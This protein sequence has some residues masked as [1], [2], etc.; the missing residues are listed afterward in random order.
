[1][2]AEMTPPA[3][4]DNEAGR[5]RA[6]RSSGL[7][8][9]GTDVQLDAIVHRAAM[10]FNVP[11]AA[12]T[13]I[14]ATRQVFKSSI[15]VGLP[16]TPRD[17]AFCGFAILGTDTLVVLNAKLDGRFAG[18]PLVQAKPGIRFYAG[19]PVY[20]AQLLPFGALCVMDRRERLLVTPEERDS[21]AALAAEVSSI[22]TNP[23][24]ELKPERGW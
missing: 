21:L 15:G 9:S 2:S 22:F 23:P 20:G 4:P 10:L 1:M 11:M 8:E 5:L 13:L 17:L 3:L 19:A 6:L 16:Y 14:D 7:L 12:I 18:N 24:I